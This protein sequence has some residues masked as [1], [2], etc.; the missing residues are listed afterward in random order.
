MSDDVAFL[1]HFAPPLSGPSRDRRHQSRRNTAFRGKARRAPASQVRSQIE[2]APSNSHVLPRTLVLDEAS[3]GT[4]WVRQVEDGEDVFVHTSSGHVQSSIPD[5]V[6]ARL[7]ELLATRPR[8]QEMESPREESLAPTGMVSSPTTEPA[9]SSQFHEPMDPAIALVED[10]LEPADDSLIDTKMHSS[11]PRRPERRKRR[12]YSNLTS[13]RRRNPLVDLFSPQASSTSTQIASTTCLFHEPLLDEINTT[14]TSDTSDIVRTVMEAYIARACT[15]ERGPDIKINPGYEAKVSTAAAVNPALP[16][17]QKTST[18]TS[19]SSSLP[20]R[21][22]ALLQAQAQINH[23][24]AMTATPSSSTRTTPVPKTASIPSHDHPPSEFVYSND[25]FY[26]PT[27][28]PRQ[29]S[30]GCACIGPCSEAKDSTC[31]CLAR[32]QM[33]FADVDGDDQGRIKGFACNE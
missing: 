21:R 15:H 22:Q 23:Q 19:T 26:H 32:Q 20:Q 33:Y 3:R 5:P 13:K 18:Q 11:P 6:W 9:H 2:T 16:W 25:F 7:C 1:G 12:Q 14:I 24:Y 28:G 31:F 29:R 17:Y 4:G 10:I 27:I 8:Q 30:K